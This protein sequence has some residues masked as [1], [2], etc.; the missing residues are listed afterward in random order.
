MIL[1]ALLCVKEHDH[2]LNWSVIFIQM[3]IHNTAI[4]KDIDTYG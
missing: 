1:F 2:H 4:E 3:D